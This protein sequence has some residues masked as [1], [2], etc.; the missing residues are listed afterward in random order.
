ML[1]WC[2]LEFL[3][4][5]KFEASKNGNILFDEMFSCGCPTGSEGCSPAK[6]KKGRSQCNNSWPRHWRESKMSHSRKMVDAWPKNTTIIKIRKN[7]RIKKRDTIWN[8]RTGQTLATI[9]DLEMSRE[10]LASRS[11]DRPREL[12]VFFIAPFSRIEMLKRNVESKFSFSSRTTRK[13]LDIV[14]KN[15][16][17]LFTL[18]IKWWSKKS[19]QLSP[20]SPH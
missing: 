19:I 15:W 1:L 20:T 11:L 17:I 8:Y 3:D 7:L 18:I 13:N 10:N 5:N 6:W 4:R 14:K 2:V 16:N 12:I 9:L